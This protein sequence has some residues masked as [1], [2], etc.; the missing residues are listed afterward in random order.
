[1]SPDWHRKCWWG[2]SLSSKACD[3]LALYVSIYRENKV[4]DKTMR[5]QDAPRYDVESAD[6]A[7]ASAQ[8]PATI[9]LSSV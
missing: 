3:H 9:P 8:R 4:L 7:T 5:S 2:H 1:M 6:G